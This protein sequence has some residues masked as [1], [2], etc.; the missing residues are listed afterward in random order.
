MYLEENEVNFWNSV[1]FDP[2]KV[3]NGFKMHENNKVHFEIYENALNFSRDNI[4]PKIKSQNDEIVSGDKVLFKRGSIYSL[5]YHNGEYIEIID[6]D[7]NVPKSEIEL[8]MDRINEEKQK[9]VD[10]LQGVDFDDDSEKRL[11]EA[12]KTRE[13]YFDLFRKEFGIEEKTLQ[14]FMIKTEGQG[15]EI[16]DSFI[17]EHNKKIEAESSEYLSDL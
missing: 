11:V 10:K 17:V 1:G 5:G 13:K 2:R 8:E 4:D 12:K 3:W 7:I 6:S 16:V 9:D 14:E 15:G